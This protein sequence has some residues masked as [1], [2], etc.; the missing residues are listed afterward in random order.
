M[1]YCLESEEEKKLLEDK[2]CNHYKYCFYYKGDDGIN[3]IHF[4]RQLEPWEIKVIGNIH[5]EQK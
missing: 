1:E 4:L 5:E 2:K 3:E